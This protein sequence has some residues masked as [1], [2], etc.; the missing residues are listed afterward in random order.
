[1]I[2]S[3]QTSRQRRFDYGV[4]VITVRHWRR[5]LITP[6]SKKRRETELVIRA[7]VCVFPFISLCQ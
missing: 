2:S 3:S 1:M 5:M 7:G 4:G 6:E